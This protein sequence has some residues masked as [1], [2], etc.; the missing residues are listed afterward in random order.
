LPR[1]HNVSKISVSLGIQVYLF[2]D[3]PRATWV[4]DVELGL[5]LRLSSS[6]WALIQGIGRQQ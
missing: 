4:V 1:Y 2:E 5:H 6:E 3:L